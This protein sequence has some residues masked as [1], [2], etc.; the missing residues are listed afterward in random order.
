VAMTPCLF[1]FRVEGDRGWGGASTASVHSL[2]MAAQWWRRV[3][4]AALQGR[5]LFSV[6]GVGDEFYVVGGRSGGS[7]AGSIKGQDAQGIH[8]V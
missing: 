4:A 6:A 2:D 1:L 3:G 8:G 7:A 5:S